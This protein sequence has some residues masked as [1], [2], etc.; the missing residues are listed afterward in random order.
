M[1]DAC[2]W[3]RCEQNTIKENS[4]LQLSQKIS[5]LPRSKPKQHNKTIKQ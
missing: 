2:F 4:L 1:S 3:Q 5:K